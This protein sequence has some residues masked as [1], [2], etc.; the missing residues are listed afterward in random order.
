MSDEQRKHSWLLKVGASIVGLGVGIALVGWSAVA[1]RNVAPERSTAEVFEVDVELSGVRL[2]C[3]PGI[4][5]P[6]SSSELDGART[7]NAADSTP[8]SGGGEVESVGS[9]DETGLVISGARSGDL[10]GMLLEGCMLPSRHLVAMPA[11]TIV[12]ERS[13]LVLSNPSSKSVEAQISLF[14]ALGPLLESPLQEVVPPNSTSVVVPAIAAADQE[15]VAVEIASDGAGVAAWLQTSGLDG[16]VPQGLARTPASTASNLQVI[17][18]ITPANAEK[19]LIFNPGAGPVEAT[20]TVLTEEGNEPLAGATETTIAGQ[21]VST[22]SLASLPEDTKA[23]KVDAD[24][25][26]FA[27]ATMARVGK[28]HEDVTD[29]TYFSRAYLTGAT[30][31]TSATL[32]A[33]E[34]VEEA[35]DLIKAKVKESTVTFANPRKNAVSVTYGDETLEVG[36]GTAVSVAAPQ[37]STPVSVS[38]TEPIAITY[39]VEVSTDRGTLTVPLVLGGQGTA[40]EQRFVTLFPTF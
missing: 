8:M 27:V 4:I 20:L 2:A 37:G 24:D 21:S 35:A 33:S 12:G 40:S 32:P 6:D 16:E 23:I 34:E 30:L 7:S 13:V 22:I 14:G 36:G 38:A 3:P 15:V 10:A 39:F 29:A 1:P 18:G 28:K 17:A 26:L 19:L 9:G 5:D 25:P 31:A 11:S